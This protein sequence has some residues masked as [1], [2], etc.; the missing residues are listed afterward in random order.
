M[1]MKISP[2]STKPDNQGWTIETHESGEIIT[3]TFADGREAA[4]KIAV[5]HKELCT[6]R[7]RLAGYR[8]MCGLIEDALHDFN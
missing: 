4:S 5:L 8:K 1:T 6:A 2:L 7:A 3:T